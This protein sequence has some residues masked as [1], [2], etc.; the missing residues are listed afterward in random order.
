MSISGAIVCCWFVLVA[1]LSVSWFVAASST[2]CVQSSDG[3]VDKKR[4]QSSSDTLAPDICS[5]CADT[6]KDDCRLSDFVKTSGNK[7]SFVAHIP[8]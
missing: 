1:L 5:V 4:V 6:I 8:C 3:V 2:P 7:V